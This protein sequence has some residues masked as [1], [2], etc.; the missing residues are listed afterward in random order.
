MAALQLKTFEDIYTAVLEELR[1]QSSDTT[2]LNRIKRLINMV[3]MDEIVPFDEWRWL[4]GNASI[5]HEPVYATGTASVTE[6]SASVT[7]SQSIGIKKEGF[8]FSVDGD[9][10]CYKIASHSASSTT[11]TLAVPFTG[12]T[13]SAAS[14]KIWSDRIPLPS[15]CMDVIR[16]SHGHMSE[17]MEGKGFRVYRDIVASSPKSE[18]RPGIYSLGDYVDP[19][20]YAT[21]S[22]LPASSTRASDGLVKTLVFASSVA[23]YL[24][25]GDRIK[26]SGSGG[27]TYNCEGVISSLAT[28][29]ITY[30]GLV[31]TTESATADTA[32]TVQLLS[33]ETND[34]NYRELFVYPS[35]N[36][37]RTLI[38]LD[39]T[40]EAR[41][42]EDDDDE[43]LMPLGDRIAIYYG[44]CMM[45]YAQLKK[46]A[47]ES[48]RH[49][50]YFYQKLGR[51][52][53]KV[54][55]STDYPVLKPSREYLGKKRQSATNRVRAAAAWGGFS[56]SSSSSSSSTPT[57][58]ANT[59]AVFNNTGDLASSPTISTTELGYLDGASSNLQTQLD[60]ITTLA[61]GKIYLGNGSNQAAEVTPNGDVTIDNTGVTA[62]TA[63]VIV[64]ADINASAAISRSK[65]ATGTANHVVINSGTGALSS[66][67]AL[68]PDRGGTGVSNNAAATLTRSGNHALTLTTSGATN[69]TLPTSGTLATLAGTETFTNKTQSGLIFTVVSKTGTYTAAATDNL[70]L[71]DGTSGGFTVN[72]PAAAS[73]AGRV[74]DFVRIDNTPA[75]AVTL[76][77]NSSETLDGSTT[78][79]LNSQY[80]ACRIICDGSNWFLVTRK[81]RSLWNSSLTFTPNSSAFGTVT[82]STFFSRRVGD[83]LEV[84]CYWACGT[85]GAAASHI[86]L[87]TSHT[88]DTA[89]MGSTAG[90]VL[91]GVGARVP[92][93]A[94][95]GIGGAT[96]YIYYDG[97]NADRVLIT[98]QSNSAVF[99]ARNGSSIFSNSDGF[100]GRFTIPISGWKG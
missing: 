27:S 84:Q 37:S 49:Q 93:G 12:S 96:L 54:D 23:S 6:N 70:I 57:G 67:A 53:G 82:N 65:V 16:A 3:Y 17:P 97:S 61:S 31:P 76:D 32:I 95:S 34:E 42:L 59:V 62:I 13:N 92:T 39:Y 50:G 85:V 25:V 10:D 40:K 80:E 29:T 11:V 69:V 90:T 15:D 60:A 55:D 81:I 28:T 73:N 51:M 66:E 94:A 75:N 64:D 8:Y 99:N 4:R 21:I 88:L 36:T 41:P 26:V 22:G 52:A 78:T 43:P 98:D 44:A 58:T 46:D 14:F 74:F 9:N 24:A 72:L 79:T 20:P 19:N 89:K 7:L 5:T 33:Q 86:S 100:A 77:G 30:T 38:N 1:I 83:S 18:G 45:G 91:L 63:G 35:I 87:P 56:G 68:A 71:V 48:A 47:T 2:S